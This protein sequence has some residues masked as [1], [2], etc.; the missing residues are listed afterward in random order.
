MGRG[1][2]GVWGGRRRESTT[3]E[4]VNEYRETEY[5]AL[6]CLFLKRA[7]VMSLFLKMIESYHFK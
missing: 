2:A 5:L 4:V 6:E 3:L 1:R 7:K